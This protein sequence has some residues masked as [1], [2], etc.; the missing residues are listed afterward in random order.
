LLTFRLKT[1]T[2]EDESEASNG[3]APEV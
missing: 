2:P 1:P 3:F